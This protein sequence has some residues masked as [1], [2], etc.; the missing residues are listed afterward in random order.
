MTLV[1]MARALG[2]LTTEELADECG[3]TA[4]ERGI[5]EEAVRGEMTA[6]T[7]VLDFRGGVDAA[8]R[9]AKYAKGALPPVAMPHRLDPYT[10]LKNG[11]DG[12]R[13]LE[14]SAKAKSGQSAA[15]RVTADAAPAPGRAGAGSKKRVVVELPR[16]EDGA[17][18]PFDGVW[19]DNRKVAEPDRRRLAKPPVKRR[20]KKS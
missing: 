9:W 17:R 19:Q 12:A 16:A 3:F 18:T 10:G 15:R 7:L 5:V 13:S 4:A 14:A 20:R 1:E 6:P 11:P 8:T 2:V